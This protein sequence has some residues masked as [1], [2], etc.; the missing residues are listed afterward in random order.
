[1]N[2]FRQKSS[3]WGES[4]GTFSRG[5]SLDHSGPRRRARS[6]NHDKGNPSYV[7]WNSKKQCIPGGGI[8]RNAHATCLGHPEK[9]RS[10]EA[11][12]RITAPMPGLIFSGVP[13]SPGDIHSAYCPATFRF[14][15]REGQ[16]CAKTL[17]RRIIQSRPRVITTQDQISEKHARDCA[18]SEP[19]SRIACSD[20]Y[21]GKRFSIS[22]SWPVL[23]SSPPMI[24]RSCA[25]APSS[26]RWSLT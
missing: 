17:P 7:P 1:V 12:L 23:W 24:S 8:L 15:F 26:T 22:S 10:F 19:C 5:R 4:C 16:R 2:R 14:S 13:T 21:I 25:L 9:Q 6:A 3:Y 20:I 18:M 11:P